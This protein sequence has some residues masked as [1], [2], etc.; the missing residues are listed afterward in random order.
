MNLKNVTLISLE[1]IEDEQLLSV[2]E[3]R[4]TAEYSWTLK[5]PL[6][7]Y[8]LKNYDF[9][10][11]IIY[12]DGDLYFYS[13]PKPI[14]NQWGDGSIYICEQQ[15]FEKK[16]NTGIYQAGLIGFKRDSNAFQ[17]LEWWRTKCLEWCFHWH[18]GDKWTDQKYLDKW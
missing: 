7:L 5:A 16:I 6:V 8:I 15:L 12:I 11:S 17:C 3:S 14:L 2:K 9:V 13:D 4:K 1:S 10:N 18:D